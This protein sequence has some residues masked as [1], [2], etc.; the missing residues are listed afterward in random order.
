MG[1]AGEFMGSL[2]LRLLTTK[3]RFG[4]L[5]QIKGIFKNQVIVLLYFEIFEVVPHP[6][7]GSLGNCL[8]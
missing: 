8:C 4:V 7:D 5:G 3:S 1:V 2:M 6:A